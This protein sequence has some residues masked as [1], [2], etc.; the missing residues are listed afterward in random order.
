MSLADALSILFV[1]LIGF[2]AHRAS[3][4]TVRAVMQW[5]D[6]RK[7]SVIIS[8]IKAGA[9][10][11]L[12]AGVFVLFG[13]PIKGVPVTHGVWWLGMVGG[14]LFGMGA[15][16]NGGCSLSTVQ[17]LANGD[18]SLLLTLLAFVLGAAGVVTLEN[19]WR[20]QVVQPQPLW[21]EQ[22]TLTQHILLVAVLLLWAIRELAMQWQRRDQGLSVWQRLAAP[23]YRLSFGALLLGVCSGLLFLLEGTWTYTNYL[24]EQTN[25]LFFHGISPGW[26]R[27]VLVMALFVGMLV[28]SFHRG[29]FRWRWPDTNNWFRR[30]L[31]GTLMGAGGALV[32]GGN[33]TLILVLIPT[34]SIQAVASY[35]ALLAGIASVLL[36]MRLIRSV[37]T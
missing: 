21:W 12:L 3:L 24:R 6:D 16:I 37:R 33:D 17:Q 26:L 35:V 18:S 4:C 5:L 22:L 36:T 28:S 31:G 13:L 30:S 27:S 1:F 15:A 20:A 10:S 19:L 9:W 23:R 8:F 14:F 7:A 29:S 25:T 2:A 11:C 32:P 34:L